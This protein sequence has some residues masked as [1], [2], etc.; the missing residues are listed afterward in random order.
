MALNSNRLN[1]THAETLTKQSVAKRAI[2]WALLLAWV[3]FIY[4]TLGTVPKWREALVDLYG[5][6]VFTILTYLFAGLSL[7]ILLAIM[8]IHNREKKLFPYLA[9]IAILF[10]LR[11]VMTHW[12]FIPVEQIHFIE[13]GIVGVLAFNALRYHLKGLA[14]VTA[15]LLLAYFFGMI[16][17]C[18]QGILIN[19]VGE[20]R[21]MFWNGLAVLMALVLVVFGLKPKAVFRSSGPRVYRVHLLVLALCLPVQGYFNSTFAQ[22]GHLFRDDAICAVFHSRLHPEE[23]KA[24]DDNL[25]HFKDAIAPNIG[26]VH[27]DTVMS[28]VHD[29]IHEEA[30]VHSFRRFYHHLRGNFPVAYKETLILSTYFPQFIRGTSLEYSRAQIR[31]LQEIIGDLTY[32]TYYSPVAEHLITKFTETQ[33]WV[34]IVV[35]EVI[36][37]IALFRKRRQPRSEN[38]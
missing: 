33:M 11:H 24:Y 30:A 32:S 6:G 22:F 17:E 29:K 37:L 1:D 18:I 4:L 38:E 9:L 5:Q 15:A 36:I 2:A 8:I 13:Y 31:E 14:L 20:Q 26:R 16:D 23:L 3:A 21:D 25:N 35:L 28:Q 27:M 10:F 7:A 19:R 12:I 34:I